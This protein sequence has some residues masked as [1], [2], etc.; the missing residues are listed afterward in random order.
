[1]KWSEHTVSTA[2]RI[3][4]NATPPKR[5]FGVPRPKGEVPVG[6]AALLKTG[7]EEDG[8]AGRVTGGSMDFPRDPWGKIAICGVRLS[9]GR[10]YALR[11]L[12]MVALSYVGRKFNSQHDLALDLEPACKTVAT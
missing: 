2:Q 11:M 10:G 3:R 7:R 12:Q 4:P 5:S 6:Q 1:M 9:L 8:F